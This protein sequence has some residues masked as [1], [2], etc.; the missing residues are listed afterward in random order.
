MKQNVGGIDK[1]VRV[2][3]GIGLL[4]LLFVLEGAAKWFG[5]IGLVPLATV[6]FGYCPLYAVLG[7]STCPAV[8]KPGQA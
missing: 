5:L 8:G 7:M 6:V 4:S 1:A 2:I 3:A